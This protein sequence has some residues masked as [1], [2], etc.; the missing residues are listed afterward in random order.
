MIL[1]GASSQSFAA[2]LAETLEEPLAAVEYDRFPDGERIVRLPGDRGGGDRAVVVCATVSADAH[3]QC[4]Q[5]QNAAAR[6]YD[7]VTTVLPYM[8]YARQDRA[9]REGEP[10]SARAMAR[11][12]S[13]GT[14]RVVLVTPHERGV[15]DFFDVPCDVVDAGPRLAHGL[16]ELAA[17]LFLAPDENALALAERVR[18]AHGAGTTDYFEKHRDRDT[19]EVTIRPHDADA[20]DRN[21][22]VIDDI[23]ATG[24][25]V[26]EAVAALDGPARVVAACVHPV[27]AANAR[28]RL[29]AAGVDRVIGTDTIERA[30]SAV[31]AAPAVAPVLRAGEPGEGA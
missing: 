25:T 2:A 14:D 8:G 29:A 10:V 22:V 19:G 21:V 13:T 24:A 31:S 7:R 4:L 1:P 27:L 12:L 17:P 6:R 26:S 3:V 15:A 18:E 28:S 5:L 11:A 23:V 30:V 9:F 20:R 16:S